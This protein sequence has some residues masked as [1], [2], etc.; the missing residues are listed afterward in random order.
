MVLAAVLTPGGILAWL[1]VGLIAG[2]LA[3]LLSRGRGF[4][5]LGD[6]VVG[7]V[8][9]FLGGLIISPFLH[10]PHVFHFWG[11]VGVALIGALVLIFILRVFRGL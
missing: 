7:L 6:I 3:G 9:A 1:L 2:V 4:G 5:C 11:S 8:G 10:G